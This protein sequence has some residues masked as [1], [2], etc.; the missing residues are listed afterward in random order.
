M[1]SFNAYQFNTLQAQLVVRL[2]AQNFLTELKR[3][4]NPKPANQRRRAVSSP[5]DPAVVVELSATAKEIL[6]YKKAPY[7]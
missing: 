3:A 7:L 6:L 5:S 1:N 2:L 4:A